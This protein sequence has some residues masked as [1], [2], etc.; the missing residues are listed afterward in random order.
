MH[1]N[2]KWDLIVVMVHLNLACWQTEIPHSY[3]QVEAEVDTLLALRKQLAQ[4]GVKVSVN[5]FVIK[6]VA[7]ALR[8]CPYMNTLYINNQ[9]SWWE[10]SV[11]GYKPKKDTGCL[12]PWKTGNSP[13]N[14]TSFLIVEEC[15]WNFS[16]VINQVFNSSV[17]TFRSWSSD[18]GS[19]HK[20]LFRIHVISF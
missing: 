7:L 6:A 14:L 17:N 18:R 1:A 19:A 15:P 16:K 11:S 8:Q 4:V 9:V 10:S 2:V 13:S 3:S 5:D 20:Y 12:P